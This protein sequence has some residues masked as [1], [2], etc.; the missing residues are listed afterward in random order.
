MKT[1]AISQRRD[2]V[3]GRDEERDAMDV[4]LA[5]IFYD[6]GFI[7][8]PLC[9]EL[10]NARGYIEALKPDAILINSGNDIGEHPKRDRLETRLLDYAKQNQIPVLAICRGTQII[11]HYCGGTLVPV[12]G[13]VATRQ[14]L[15]GEWAKQHGYTTV[16][17]YHNYAI[18]TNTLAPELQALA[19]TQD[20]VI[21][22]LKHK[23][24]PWL[25]IMWHPERE[26]ELCQSDK[27]LLTSFL[28][29]ATT[30]K[31]LNS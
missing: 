5:P 4:R 21:K 23:T 10:Y 2:K 6:Q 1:I 8:V 3:L 28:N 25:G 24:L 16:N 22:A 26:T 7:P 29:N 31:S 15:L 12:T 19:Y 20:G 11:N 17:S 30:H 27:N 13:H 18:T 9:S 14:T